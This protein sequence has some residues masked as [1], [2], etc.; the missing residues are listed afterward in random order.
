MKLVLGGA[1]LGQNYGLKI[2]KKIPFNEIKSI[3]SLCKKKNVRHIDTALS[4]KNSHKTIGNTDLKNLKII[5]KLK[6][7]QEKKNIEN[8]LDVKFEKILLELKTKKIES[9]IIHDYRDII[10]EKGK[11]FLSFLRNLK[12]KKII[13]KIGISIYE[14]KELDLAW[15]I[16][17]PDLVQVPINLVDQRFIQSKWPSKLKKYNIKIFA[18]SCFLQGLLLSNFTNNKIIS[19]KEKINLK[20]FENWCKKKKITKLKACLHFV[21]GLK[22]VNFLVVGFNS[23]QNLAEIIK[24]FNERQIKITKAF[25]SINKKLIDPRRWN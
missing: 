11:I 6:L 1:Q 7:P 2:K 16:I 3:S 8:W 25:K 22:Y 21:K 24:I 23:H 15:K 10:G 12:K 9:V 13:K 20:K 18:R 5:T 4:Y 19:L 14:T 17:K